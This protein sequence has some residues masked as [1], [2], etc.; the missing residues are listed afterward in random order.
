MN[1]VDTEHCE[2]EPSDAN[3]SET[4]SVLGGDFLSFYRK[5]CYPD[6]NICIEGRVFP[7]HRAILCGRSR[8]FAAMLSGSWAESSQ[9]NIHL[10]GLSHVEVDVMM[11]FIY[12]ATL[13]IPS[14]ADVGQV[15]SLADMY[16]L[17]GLRDVAVYVLKRDY[18]KFFCKPV[19]GMQQSVL[20]CLVIAH[21]IGEESLYIPCM[22]WISTHFVKCLSERSFAGLPSDLQR[23]CLNALTQS[24]N[25][26]NAAV[27]LMDCDHLIGSL[28]GVKWAEKSLA[29]A[30]ELQQ[31]CIS[32]IV[33]HFSDTIETVGFHHLLQ[34]QAMS[35]TPYL[36]ERLI[37][38]IEKS[39]TTENCCSYF[40]GL[41]TLK[42]KVLSEN[43][44]FTCEIQALH[45]KLWLFLVQSFYAVRHTEG[46]K[47]MNPDDRE[48]IQA[49]ALDKGDDRRLSK[50]PVFSSSQNKY[51]SS[52]SKEVDASKHSAS[53]LTERQSS[54]SSSLTSQKKMKSDG[55]GTSGPQA[56]GS[57]STVNKFP[58]KTE[59]LKRKDSNSK[60]ITARPVKDVKPEERETNGTLKLR[61][62]TKPKISTT[63]NKKE[64]NSAS[65]EGIDVIN[66]TNGQKHAIAKP[67]KNH[68]GGST[69]SKPKVSTGSLASQS[70]F[71]STARKT[72][73]RG[74]SQ[75]DLSRSSTSTGS[76]SL[77]KD[78]CSSSKHSRESCEKI[79]AGGANGISGTESTCSM[80]PSNGAQDIH[81]Q[82]LKETTRAE[83]M[84]SSIKMGESSGLRKNGKPRTSHATSSATVKPT[85][86][87][88]TEQY[89]QT[90][91]K[92]RVTTS[93]TS[94][95]SHIRSSSSSPIATKNQDSKGNVPNVQKSMT[96]QKQTGNVS[97]AGIK[98]TS[99]AIQ[100]G[101]KNVKQAH[102]ATSAAMKTPIK[103]VAIATDCAEVK[104]NTSVHKAGQKPINSSDHS[105]SK[106]V[107]T[108]Q[109]SRKT[110]ATK[111]QRHCTSVEDILNTENI[112]SQKQDD[113]GPFPT[114]ESICP[115]EESDFSN[116][117]PQ[118]HC[119][120][121]QMRAFAK[122]S[123]MSLPSYG[124]SH[125]GNE[126]PKGGLH[127]H[128]TGT[129]TDGDQIIFSNTTDD[130]ECEVLCSLNESERKDI[131]KSEACK[132]TLQFAVESKAENFSKCVDVINKTDHEKLQDFRESVS[133]ASNGLLTET[134]PVREDFS[135]EM[136]C[137]GLAIDVRSG[138]SSICSDSIINTCLAAQDKREPNEFVLEG[139]TATY[140]K[141]DHMA[142][143]SVGHVPDKVSDSP[144]DMDTTETPE[145]QS[146]SP[147]IDHHWNLTSGILH[148]KTSPESDS[149]SATTSSDDIKPRSED[150]DAGGSQDDDG[151]NERGVSKCSTMLCHDFLGR[152]SSDTS[153]PEEL[154][155]YDT[156]L[157]VEVRS[158]SKETASDHCH[159]NST[160][161]DDAAKKA[162]LWSHQE[163]V[164]MDEAGEDD[165]VISSNAQF[166]Y[167]NDQLSSSA[168][169]TEDEK[170]ET[171]NAAAIPPPSQ[172]DQVTHHFEGIVN[173]AFED[174]AESETGAPEHSLST[175]FRRSVLLSVDECEELGSD[176]GEGQ[177]TSC[178]LTDSI[179]SAEVHDGGTNVHTAHLG[180]I[181]S[182][183]T[184][185]TSDNLECGLQNKD[186][187]T[188]ENSFICPDVC[189]ME[190]SDTQQ[191]ASQSVVK[192]AEQ[193]IIPGYTY[194]STECCITGNSADDQDIRDQIKFNKAG[195]TMQNEIYNSQAANN[196]NEI[197]ERP[198]HL[199]LSHSE[200]ASETQRCSS[201]KDLD[202]R[203]LLVTN[204]EG[205]GNE[206]S[207]ASAPLTNT[208][209]PT[210]DLDDYET[211]TY[212]CIHDRR[213]SKSLSPICELDVGDVFE[214]AVEAGVPFMAV[215]QDEQ[216][217]FAERDWILLRQLLADQQDCLDIKNSVPEDINLAQYL[218]N[219][220]LILSRD[221]SKSQGKVPF[222]RE[223]VNRWSDLLSPL[224]DSTA[225]I[226]VAS[227]S[228][229]DVSSPQ[230][231][232]TIVELETHH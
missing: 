93:T 214:P 11:N 92:K 51:T 12:G 160:S 188:T 180:K 198:Y 69:G 34:A 2:F 223:I 111:N 58:L 108:A 141:Q 96:R 177:M 196:E 113:L 172:T 103:S 222:E 66:P 1:E 77:A 44:G 164:I 193:N 13:D 110:C 10:Q 15:L 3:K 26:K 149:G 154:K 201:T 185:S 88:T 146:D 182:E 161:E 4:A 114:L 192:S 25:R 62:V 55:L 137:V 210:G 220:T 22:R 124:H 98:D 127:L 135:N 128:F 170:S 195:V 17:E 85:V 159:V 167:I 75:S 7:V 186:K 70:K 82:S 191:C 215:D 153:T 89:L 121:Q 217:L 197:Q 138:K 142:K 129:V 57:R 104:K 112:S 16:G 120:P 204:L 125:V 38:A 73:G 145:G 14:E 199:K 117:C 95:V 231:E 36:L 143:Y 49:A 173:L 59:D 230:G 123:E 184:H 163:D 101:R 212:T 218:I 68:N 144:N 166:T 24:L 65:Q 227:F 213:P 21:K 72:V 208:T 80:I 206:S 33:A 39:L 168:D 162:D 181:Y 100:N 90:Q 53:E 60:K 194:H 29:F 52:R 183:C 8:Y 37:A 189:S 105:P 225:S 87:G 139:I 102:T 132:I 158:K 20:D 5:C 152:S 30:S 209:L 32:Y 151:S 174:A 200:P 118:A 64:E 171:E 19:A 134:E 148:Q 119:S 107:S 45:D 83:K 63:G 136:N 147:F 78:D 23:A 216:K 187:N 47:L 48:K 207:P 56:G 133:E 109:S 179:I 91:V 116:Q 61:S 28:P 46:W 35:S 115:R 74:I 31:E 42:R 122:S 9:E 79:D 76:A 27:F 106:P 178:H 157:R 232:W 41:T 219:Q 229:E 126:V 150:Y 156:G 67:V 131:L 228:P 155:I 176:E 224:E 211:L 86:K 205:Q 169:E 71:Q 130:L 165:I 50:K 84:R 99:D 140:S 202:H 190:Y 40:I 175:K 94:S 18:C 6:V 221:S 226:T 97:A 203:Q 54:R 81:S 43:L